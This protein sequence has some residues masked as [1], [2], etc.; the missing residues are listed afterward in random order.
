MIY[1]ENEFNYFIN[2]DEYLTFTRIKKIKHL[3]YV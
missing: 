1:N 3:F 2:K